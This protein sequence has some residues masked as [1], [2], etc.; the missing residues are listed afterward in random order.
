MDGIGSSGYNRAAAG[1]HAALKMQ[2]DQS[3]SLDGWFRPCVRS[4]SFLERVCYDFDS[5]SRKFGSESDF[6]AAGTMIIATDLEGK[7]RFFNPAAE[8]LLGWSAAEVVGHH[9]PVLWHD[10]EELTARAA[11]LSHELGRTMLPG[12]EV[13]VAKARDQ[14]NEERQW[15]FIRKDGN[16][17]PVSLIVSA[18]RDESGGI[19][20]YVGTAKDLTI[21]V[22]AEQER[23]R[24]FN[25]SLD[26]LGIASTD[27]YFKRINPTF[28]RVLGWTDEEFLSRPFLDFVHPADRAATA[29]EAEKLAAGEPTLHFENRYRCKDGSWRWIAWTCATQPDSS[30]YASGRDVT[31]LKQAEE[32]LRQTQQDLAIT[33]N[34]IGDAVLATD[35]A[36]RIT[37]MNP[38]AEQLTGWTQSE[39]MGRPIDKVFHIINEET[40]LPAVIPV[41]DVLATGTVQGLANHT[42]LISRNGAECPIA[43]CAAPI[44]D[45]AGQIAGVVLVFRDASQ[46][47]TFER[48]LQESNALLEEQ[49]ALRTDELQKEQRR[50]RHGNLVLESIASE[51]PIHET[52]QLITKFVTDEGSAAGY[53][54]LLLDER[55]EWLE[56]ILNR[57]LPEGFAE[58]L[59]RPR[60]DEPTNWLWQSILAAAR[61][62]RILPKSDSLEATSGGP[63]G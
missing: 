8:R 45:D 36:R 24:Y 13:F 2:P 32:R 51:A 62:L 58:A 29:R 25:F 28:N 44:I 7:V 3:W 53:G 37:R 59:I 61:R 31:E 16:R 30:L 57:N 60:V 12:F 41:D 20:G 54:I 34:S 6:D 55:H 1:L 22:K 27:G 18:I 4:Q 26:L 5:I 50:L 42:L 38:V 39:A 10:R 43:D 33:L 40:R 56:P 17:F 21:R 48:E 15:T 35:A 63:V 49:V 47:R 19:T 9:T 52:I 46:E 23:D 11:E 14:L